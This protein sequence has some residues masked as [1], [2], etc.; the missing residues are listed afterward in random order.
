MEFRVY[1]AN[2][3]CLCVNLV[4]ILITHERNPRLHVCFDKVNKWP[5]I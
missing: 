4:A 3:Q 1:L 2:A 5:N